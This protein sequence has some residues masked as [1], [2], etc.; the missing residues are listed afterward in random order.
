MKRIGSCLL[1]VGVVLLVPAR[2][3]ASPL[4]VNYSN[5]DLSA[6]ASFDVNNNTLLVT[7]TNLSLADPSSPSSILTAVFFDIT[8]DPTLTPLSAQIC[9][10]CTVTYGGTTDSNKSVAGEWAYGF[11]STDLAY[12]TNYGISSSGLGIFGPANLFP[13]GTN[14]AGPITPDGVQY[15]ITTTNDTAA[16]DNG[17]LSGSPL[18]SNQ[19]MFTLS[20]LPEG[21]DVSSISGVTFQYGTALNE[22]PVPEPGTLALCGSGVLAMVAGRRR[23]RLA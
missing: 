18:I 1:V 14:L 5:G 12:G 19:V 9:A 22:V 8:G 4:L 2:G 16:N 10:T 20:G 21:F 15:G 13:N 17:G 11:S 7:L 3:N 6:S 23:K